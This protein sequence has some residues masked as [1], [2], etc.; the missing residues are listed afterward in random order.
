MF[1][2][3]FSILMTVALA[4]ALIVALARRRRRS[5][6]REDESLPFG[7]PVEPPVKPQQR[8]RV[9]SRPQAPRDPRTPRLWAIRWRHGGVTVIHADDPGRYIGLR[10]GD[11]E[12]GWPPE[13]A[14]VACLAPV[15]G[16]RFTVRPR[17]ADNEPG[18]G[19]VVTRTYVARWDRPGTPVV[20]AIGFLVDARRDRKLR[21]VPA[22]RLGCELWAWVRGEALE[23]FTVP[24]S[25]STLLDTRVARQAL[26]AE[27]DDLDR[28]QR[29]E[30]HF[31]QR[32]FGLVPVCY[33]LWIDGEKV[34]WPRPASTSVPT[35]PD[36][37]EPD[38]ITAWAPL[39]RYD[40]SFPDGERRR[41]SRGGA[42]RRPVETGR[43]RA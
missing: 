5:A 13:D 16:F 31:D 39:P 27:S 26:E 7:P 34:G 24:T 30:C 1:N 21:G 36:G 38:T 33:R 10:L 20:R 4:L 17:W 8:S 12:D 37:N 23:I 14:R 6:Y 18:P 19:H 3:T 29:L 35:P 2:V 42:W 22:D 25:D 15:Q 28:I 9:I 41:R 43:D 11:T 40:R 32:A